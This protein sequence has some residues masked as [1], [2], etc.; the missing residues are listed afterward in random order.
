M[1][2]PV[3]F[4]FLSTAAIPSFAHPVDTSP[5]LLNERTLGIVGQNV[6][7]FQNVTQICGT[8]GPSDEL[9]QA[10]ADY[11]EQSRQG[12][13]ERQAN[14]PIVVQTYI[15]FV[16]TTDQVKH[17]P[18]SVRTTMINSQVIPLPTPSFVQKLVQ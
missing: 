4:L 11:L 2:L 16:S 18:S 3:S 13:K 14:A 10:H 15:H 5:D 6:S 9:R 17:Y 12:K 8:R 7:L 1:L